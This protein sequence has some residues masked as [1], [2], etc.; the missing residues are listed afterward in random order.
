MGDEKETE[1]MSV[2][3]E[4]PGKKTANS[5]NSRGKPTS[6]RAHGVKCVKKR[7]TLEKFLLFLLLIVLFFVLLLIIVLV[8]KSRKGSNLCLSI[9]CVAAAGALIENMDFEAD[10]CQDFYQY[11]CGGWMKKTTIPE[12]E[13]QVTV[14]GQQQ[15]KLL[16]LT[17]G[18]L[19]PSIL[20][21]D[22]VAEVR[23]R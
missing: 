8:T 23:G 17:R 19:E 7:T 16:V 14:L 15:D 2:A 10:P 22:A 18:L 6:I 21:W 20:C 4:E 3:V 5:T 9:D 13:N 11:S 1:Y 12:E